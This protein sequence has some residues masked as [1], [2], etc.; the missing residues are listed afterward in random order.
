MLLE[1]EL[2]KSVHILPAVSFD[3]KRTIATIIIH[4]DG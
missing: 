3:S 2:M 1:R 4:F